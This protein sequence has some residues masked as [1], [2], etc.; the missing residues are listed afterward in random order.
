MSGFLER[1]GHHFSAVAV[2]AG[3]SVCVLYAQTFGG[4]HGRVTDSSGAVIPGSVHHTHQYQHQ[5]RPAN[6]DHRSRRVYVSFPVSPGLYRLAKTEL[7]GI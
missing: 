2:V 5:R 6:G 4:G 1:E 7:R 3:F